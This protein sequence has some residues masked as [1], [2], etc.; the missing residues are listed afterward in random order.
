MDSSFSRTALLYG[1]SAMEYQGK[2][3]QVTQVIYAQDTSILTCE[4]GL[5]NDH[6]GN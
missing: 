5:F 4:G 1:E 3:Y 6:G 2:R